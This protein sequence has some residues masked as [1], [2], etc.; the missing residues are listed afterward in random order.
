MWFAPVITRFTS[1][2]M[3]F[4]PMIFRFNLTI[5]RFDSAFRRCTSEEKVDFIFSECGEFALETWMF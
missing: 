5:M 2:M 3:K 4:N 1:V